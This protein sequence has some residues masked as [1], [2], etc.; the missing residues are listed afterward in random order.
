MIE[1][2]TM[3]PFRWCGNKFMCFFCC[4]MFHD[5]TEL[6]EHTR[7]EHENPKLLNV[8]KRPHP[9]RNRI[10]FDVSEVS[11]TKCPK[12]FRNV[13]DFLDHAFLTHD[14]KFN[15]DASKY[16][17]CVELTDGEMKC[18]D[19][20][21]RFKF[22]GTLLSHAYRYHN[23]QNAFLCEICGQGFA[24]KDQAK[25]HHHFYHSEAKCEKCPKKFKTKYLLNVHNDKEHKTFQCPK[26][27]QVL[28]SRYLKKRHMAVVHDVKS[29][30]FKCNE[31]DKVF[32]MKNKLLEHKE[33]IHLKLKPTVCPICG[34]RVFNKELLKRHMVRHDDARPFECDICKKSFQRKKTLEYHRRIHTSDRRHACRICGKAFVQVASLKL[35][36]RVHH[37]PAEPARWDS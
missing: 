27:P 36:L 4:C 34:F 3:M 35:H 20:N 2:S 9:T 24:S 19:C 18:L 1:N 23:S 37:A 7:S 8:L 28:G 13:N 17:Y 12:V 16:L 29:V 31:C 5:V 10:K 33:R 22:F 30:Q 32:I 6:K 11:C 21:E 14:L 26:C 25:N 15:K